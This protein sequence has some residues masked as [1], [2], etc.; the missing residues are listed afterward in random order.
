MIEARHQRTHAV[1]P[2]ERPLRLRHSHARRAACGPDSQAQKG[3]WKALSQ[4]HLQRLNKAKIDDHCHRAALEADC[5]IDYIKDQS[6]RM[7]QRDT[8]F[9]FEASGDEESARALLA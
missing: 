8:V 6:L 2:P 1:I 7:A 3:N 4:H 9:E 5:W